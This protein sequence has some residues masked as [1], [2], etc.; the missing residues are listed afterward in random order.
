M[1]CPTCREDNAPTTRFCTS[2][3][4]VLVE[5]APGGGRRRVLRPWGL[6][7]SAPL[8]ISPDY[9]D[10]AVST[11]LAERRAWRMDLGLAGGVVA[12]V[13]LAATLHP[14]LRRAEAEPTSRVDE[15]VVAAAATVSVPA[16]AIVYETRLAA[17]ALVER[18]PASASSEAIAAK[19]AASPPATGAA[20]RPGGARALPAVPVNYAMTP[21]EA[22]IGDGQGVDAP[23]A[24]AP[25][26]APAPTAEPD[27][28]QVL[29]SEL[30]RCQ[31]LGVFERA[32][33]EQRARL[34]HCDSY[35][36]HAALCP[37]LRAESGR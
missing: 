2:C 3:G 33:C 37:S 7:D 24:P 17:P 14:W 28:W 32:T 16:P 20:P 18:A 5:E 4:A 29:R 9:P 35:W 22:I 36:G 27:R 1:H 34:S 21:R 10:L 12:I 30:D 8:T 26:T 11:I 19:T 13:V 15:R 23:V 25:A 6:R 31:P